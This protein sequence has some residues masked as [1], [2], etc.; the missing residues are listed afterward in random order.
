MIALSRINNLFCDRFMMVTLK[1]NPAKMQL[2]SGFTAHFDL[3][4]VQ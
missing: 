4:V 2:I 1:L 3:K